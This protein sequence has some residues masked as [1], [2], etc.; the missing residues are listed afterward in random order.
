MNITSQ[1]IEILQPFE[2]GLKRVEDIYAIL[3]PSFQVSDKFGI[4]EFISFTV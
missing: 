2:H 1:A 3:K 4:L